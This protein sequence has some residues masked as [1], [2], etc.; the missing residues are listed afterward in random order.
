ME[1]GLPLALPGSPFL[2]PGDEVAESEEVE[3]VEEVRVFEERSDGEGSTETD[4]L[5]LLPVAVRETLRLK[6]VMLELD[7]AFEK[8]YEDDLLKETVAVGLGRSLDTLGEPLGDP[9]M[10]GESDEETLAEEVALRVKNVVPDTVAITD[11]EIVERAESEVLGE[12]ERPGERVTE[13]ESI[14]EEEKV[15]KRREG[16]TLEQEECV[17]VADSRAVAETDWEILEL[18]LMDAREVL[19]STELEEDEVWEG[20]ELEEEVVGCVGAAESV[21][22]REGM[23]VYV[24]LEDSEGMELTDALEVAVKEAQL[25]GVEVGD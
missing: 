4:P 5:R 21:P 25:E 14:E 24:E 9:E 12:K 3:V 20:E 19:L 17:G 15:G 16:V 18:G 22:V 10:E 6:D 13:R 7:G 11:T 2:E 1:D 8:V 23:A